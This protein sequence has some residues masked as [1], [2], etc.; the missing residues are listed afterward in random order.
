M[1][2]CSA[3]GDVLQKFKTTEP[4]RRCFGGGGGRFH[5]GEVVVSFIQERRVC[6][7]E[8]QNFGQW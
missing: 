5:P 1:C 8:D 4:G 6:E 3:M 7:K 2:C